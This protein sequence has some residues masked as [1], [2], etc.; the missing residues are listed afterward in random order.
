VVHPEPTQVS[1]NQHQHANLLNPH[2]HA[3]RHLY[4]HTWPPSAALT[5]LILPCSQGQE[6]EWHANLHIG[7]S[8]FCAGQQTGKCSN[9]C[10]LYTGMG[11]L[12][13][14]LRART[15]SRKAPESTHR[16]APDRDAG[17]VAPAM[18][19]AKMTVRVKRSP[20]QPQAYLKP[21]PSALQ[22]LP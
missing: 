9:R 4:I 7:G 2:M 3:E 21:L 18:L 22:L 19:A 5:I 17:G 10:C 14:P 11:D 12:A 15:T 20:A 1:S 8:R 16:P 6:V 13:C